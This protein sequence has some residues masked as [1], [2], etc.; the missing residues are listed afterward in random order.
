MSVVSSGN[1]T[2]VKI[3]LTVGR[4]ASSWRFQNIFERGCFVDCL[5]S[6]LGCFACH[7][8]K[9]LTEVIFVGIAREL[10]VHCSD[11]FV[12]VNSFRE[13]NGVQKG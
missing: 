13:K 11:V 7:P 2:A 1:L 3:S 9:I 10:S 12:F 6:I 8:F 5:K 4:F